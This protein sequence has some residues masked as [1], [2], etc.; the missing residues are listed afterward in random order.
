MLLALDIGN[1]EI[2]VGLFQATPCGPVAAHPS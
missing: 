2:T 1:T